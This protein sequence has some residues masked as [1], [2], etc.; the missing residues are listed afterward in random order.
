MGLGAGLL[1]IPSIPQHFAARIARLLGKQRPSLEAGSAS[2]VWG[3]G[4]QC[5]PRGGVLKLKLLGFPYQ[6]PLSPDSRS[7]AGVDG[8]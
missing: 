7:P 3:G 1:G 6:G 4:G 2:P 8:L 5:K